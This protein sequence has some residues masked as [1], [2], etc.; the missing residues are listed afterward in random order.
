MGEMFNKA[1][2]RLKTA[3]KHLDID[4]EVIE[5]LRYPKETLAASLL[6]RMDDGS[7]R[8][9]K[10]FRCRYDDSRG[11][12]KGGIRYHPAVNMDEVMT[13]AFWMTFKCA[14]ANLPFG[15]GK[16]GVAVD[17]HKLSRAELERLSRAYVKAFAT[18][19]GPDRDIPAPDMY[20]NGMVMGWMVD[21]YSSIVGY[22]SPAVI[23]G[24]PI[25]LGGSV[26]RE[27]ATGRGG[28]LVLRH[29][30]KELRLSPERSRVIVQGFGNVAFWCAK[31]LAA[32]GYRIC[33]VSDSRAGLYDPD[34]MDP[35]AVLDHKAKTGRL[36]GAP[37]KGKGRIVSNADL[38]TTECDVLVPAAMENQI[39]EEN[40]DRVA[41]SV[42]LELANGP[43]TPAADEILNKKGVTIIPDILANAGGVTVSYFEWVQNKA[44]FYW[45]LEEVQR[46]LKDIMVPEALRIYAIGRDRAV[47]LRTAAYVHALDRIGKAIA[48]HGTKSFFA[49]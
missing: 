16:G 4:P 45:G 44:G 34:G 37:T 29:L 21:E 25:A 32:D 11:P 35:D 43:T 31:L 1:R 48:A 19:I 28:Y 18:F 47:D 8:V 39:V 23:T 46:R 20:T 7:R 6:V 5:K 22:P 2:K 3:A 17:V 12:T 42:I 15:G 33:G 10:A 38:L 30:E 49:G 40:A 36:D 13:L 26:G 27:D 14:V 9:F 41:A 24:K